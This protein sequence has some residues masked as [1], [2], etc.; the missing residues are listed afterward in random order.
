MTLFA[1]EEAWPKFSRAFKIPVYLVQDGEILDDFE[2]TLIQP[3]HFVLVSDDEDTLQKFQDSRNSTKPWFQ[4][5]E[6]EIPDDCGVYVG[7]GGKVQR[8]NTVKAQ[9]LLDE[10][11][12]GLQA[13][14][15]KRN[16][17]DHFLT[18]DVKSLS[19]RIQQPDQAGSIEPKG[20]EKWKLSKIG[21]LISDF[22]Q[23]HSPT[24]M[25]HLLRYQHALTNICT[26]ANPFELIANRNFTEDQ[27]KVLHTLL[28]AALVSQRDHDES[29]SSV[30]P[31]SLEPSSSSTSESSSST[32]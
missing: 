14:E 16:S 29:S 25:T 32:D 20:S 9:L 27:K 22:D 3:R 19:Q 26:V 13:S 2:T 12:K 18:S 5:L 6:C 8:L 15:R 7:N 1:K 21:K 17:L 4:D 30:D 31:S 28:Y 11:R 10:F 24:D 23:E